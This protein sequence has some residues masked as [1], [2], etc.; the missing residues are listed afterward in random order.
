VQRFAVHQNCSA[1]TVL[2]GAPNWPSPSDYPRPWWNEMVP[3]AV[4]TSIFPL[5]NARRFVLQLRPL[6][7]AR[8]EAAS[9][10]LR[11]PAYPKHL[12]FC[13]PAGTLLPQDCNVNALARERLLAPPPVTL[14]AERGYEAV[15]S[16]ERNRCSA[17]LLSCHAP[18]TQR[19]GR[20]MRPCAIGFGVRHYDAAAV[21]PAESWP[22]R[23]AR[24]PST[25]LEALLQS[26]DHRPR[27]IT[28]SQPPRARS[29]LA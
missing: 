11:G 13:H 20:A 7:D 17:N 28:G 29:S 12:R 27:A 26:K 15:I 8:T 9:R 22:S 14:E 2:D 19:K 5:R 6:F 24:P 3:G 23:P 21:A 1:K 18:S 16:R 4:Q 25:V 10:D